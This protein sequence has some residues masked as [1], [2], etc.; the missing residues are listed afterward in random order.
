MRSAICTLFEGSYHY[1]LAA[2]ANSLHGSGFRGRLYA[3]YRGALPEWARAA[4]PLPLPAW[5]Q[6][7]LLQLD[8]DFGIVFIPLATAYHLTNVKPEFM[9]SLLDGPAC[10]A[11]ALFYFD[12][13]ICVT[14][15]WTFFEQWV[16]CGVALCEDMN[17]PLPQ[18]HPRRVGWRRYYNA[19]GLAL[20]FRVSEYVN[21]GFVGLRR[22]DRAFLATWHRTME[23]MAE[24]IGTLSSAKI[25]GGQAYRS[26]GFADCFD[27]SDQDALNAA[28]EASAIPVSVIGQ[29][30][31][32]FKPGAAL[33]PHAVGNGK[34]WQRSY[35]RSA[36]KG[37]APRAADK[38]FWA[39]AGSPIA[40]HGH[41]YTAFKRLDIAAGGAI[42]RFMRR[43]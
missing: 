23:L 13:D 42:G 37:V 25:L 36:L 1:G 19:R 43:A 38:A 32:A 27:C 15:R 34:P 29:E 22:Q 17:S 18:L 31:M 12:P 14:G 2:L 11:D 8:A 16:D 6:A 7:R 9:L 35:L 41:L 20:Q 5:P 4:R 10:D 40:A 21:G 39:H 30:A 26:T 3:G 33:L 28:V 24:E